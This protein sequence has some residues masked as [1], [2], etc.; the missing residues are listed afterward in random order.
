MHWLNFNVESAAVRPGIGR[1][2]DDLSDSTD[3]GKE[4]KL[5]LTHYDVLDI[6]HGFVSDMGC[7]LYLRRFSQ[8][9]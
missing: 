6:K 2:E 9:L 7:A 1:S 3:A 5:V 4:A 8:N